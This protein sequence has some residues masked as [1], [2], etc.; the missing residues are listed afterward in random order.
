MTLAL[1]AVVKQGV[2]LKQPYGVLNSKNKGFLYPVAHFIF[3]P[4]S[5]LSA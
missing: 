3:C 2:M 4:T 5:K 1:L